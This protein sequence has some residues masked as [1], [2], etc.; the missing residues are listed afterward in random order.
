MGLYC[1]CI[2][3]AV[4]GCVGRAFGQINHKMSPLW[5]IGIDKHKMLPLWNIDIGN[6]IPYSKV[7]TWGFKVFVF[8]DR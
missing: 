1:T 2:I 3:N 7:L 5:N 6:H 4:K 8:E